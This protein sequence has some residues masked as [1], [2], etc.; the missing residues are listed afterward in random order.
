MKK[1]VLFAF[2]FMALQKVAIAQNGGGCLNAISIAPGIHIVDSMISGSASFKDILPNPTKAIWYKFTPAQ[3]G[4]I[5]ISSCS[6]GA[7]TRLFV[8]AGKCDSLSLFGFNDDFCSKDASGDETASDISKQ[9]KAGR[10]YFIEWDNAWDT[11]RFTFTLSFSSTFSPTERQTCQTARIIKPGTTRVDSIFGIA[12]HGDAGHANWYKFTPTANGKISI[13][14]CGT[15]ADT[16]LWMYKGECN[17]LVDVAES[18]DECNGETQEEIAVAITD[19]AVAANTA[20][21]FEFDDSWEN[22]PF[23]FTLTFDALS[24]TTDELFSKNISLSPNPA[25][26]A[27]NL[28]FDLDKIV[29]VS[30]RIH[31]SLGQTV[32]MQKLG[33]V[34]RQEARIDT[35]GLGIGIYYVEIVSGAH[36]T[37]KKLVINR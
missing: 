25:N 18:D 34:Q 26:D 31:N 13:S 30:V 24:S 9:V 21:Y 35:S 2:I 6:G 37:N 1:T 22:V 33:T 20:Y 10:T 15:D 27:I 17:N 36:R 3:D 23:D 8:Y 7:D 11:A 5:S 32:F 16:R 29:D 14:T 12:T 4:F 28:R 19:L